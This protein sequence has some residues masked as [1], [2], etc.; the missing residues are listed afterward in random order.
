M[1]ILLLKLKKNSSEREI[2]RNLVS[3]RIFKHLAIHYQGTLKLQC[4][5]PLPGG[6]NLT[7]RAKIEWQLK[8][9]L[10]FTLK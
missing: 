8:T 4:R 2:G 9:A 1:G 3:K 6:S 7:N 10:K 5:T